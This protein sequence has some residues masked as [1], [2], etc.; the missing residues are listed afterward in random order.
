MYLCTFVLSLYGMG[1]YPPMQPTYF[2]TDYTRGATPYVRTIVL[3]TSLSL[4]P[5]PLLPTN[6]NLNP[7]LTSTRKVY[8]SFLLTLITELTPLLICSYGIYTIYFIN[9]YL[10]KGGGEGGG[11]SRTDDYLL[12]F[13]FSISVFS[14]LGIVYVRLSFSLS[15]NLNE[16]TNLTLIPRLDLLLGFVLGFCF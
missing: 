4:S 2:Q 3:C 7:T 11:G 16:R 14:G 15:L 9:T 6:L 1:V 13:W 10:L 12:L 5:S 8:L